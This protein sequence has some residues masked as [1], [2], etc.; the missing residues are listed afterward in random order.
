MVAW[1][2]IIMIH[3]FQLYFVYMWY[4]WVYYEKS[5][6]FILAFYMKIC[7]YQLLMSLEYIF[8]VITF[9]DFMVFLV[10]EIA[11]SL[12]VLLLFEHS[13]FWL[14]DDSMNSFWSLCFLRMQLKKCSLLF[15]VFNYSGRVS[16]EVLSL[17][18]A[19]FEIHWNWFILINHL[20]I[21]GFWD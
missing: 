8:S 4:Q 2:V 15:S 7:F 19:P 20:S 9:C 12:Y 18:Y 11:C 14:L 10:H 6:L 13:L 3:S 17:S 5:L 16:F 1:L 21:L